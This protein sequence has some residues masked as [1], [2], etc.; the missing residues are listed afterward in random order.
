MGL[1]GV[2]QPS[3]R[4]LTGRVSRPN[5]G[6]DDFDSSLEKQRLLLLPYDDTVVSWADHPPTILYTGLD[7]RRCHYTA[8]I[9]I[10]QRVL[11]NPD[12]VVT[13][14]EECKYSDELIAQR[15]VWKDKWIAIREHLRAHGCRFRIFTELAV[16]RDR[17]DNLRDL[18]RYANWT[19]VTNVCAEIIALL[20]ADGPL[21]FGQIMERAESPENNRP[22]I[23]AA[24]WFLIGHRKIRCDLNRPIALTTIVACA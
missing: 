2:G 24:L 20:R 21:T 9:L 13:Y 15:A 16:N 10:R 8:D 14:Y 18:R 22:T 6:L 4:S 5:G 23:C 7:G 12:Q 17:L 1:R 19:F 3:S 11:Q